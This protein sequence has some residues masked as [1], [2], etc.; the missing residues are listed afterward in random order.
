MDIQPTAVAENL[1]PALQA[2]GQEEPLTS[3]AS[4]PASQPDN[5]EQDWLYSEI[6]KGL[7]TLRKAFLPFAPKFNVDSF[8]STLF[9]WYQAFDLAIALRDQERDAARIS[10]A[11]ALAA[12][13]LRAWPAPAEVIDLMPPSPASKALQKIKMPEISAAEQE[14]GLAMLRRL[15]DPNFLAKTDSAIQLRKKLKM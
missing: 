12:S 3:T 8:K 7:N 10:A 4:S 5:H 2:L 11:F 1:K 9:V 13:Q 14:R 15:Q 6:A